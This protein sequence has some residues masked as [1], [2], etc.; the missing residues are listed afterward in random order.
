MAPQSDCSRRLRQSRAR[1]TTYRLTCIK[2]KTK[3]KAY[4]KLNDQQFLIWYENNFLNQKIKYAAKIFFVMSIINCIL[5][6][7]FSV[8]VGTLYGKSEY[9]IIPQSIISSLLFTGILSYM[10]IR[11]Y[12]FI[13]S[14][15]PDLQHP[16]SSNN[17]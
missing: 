11:R 9:L 17:E 16:I 5:S 8:T 1:Q 6:Y 4:M 12:R 2:Y 13:K 7:L 15:S 3:D 14:N 10:H